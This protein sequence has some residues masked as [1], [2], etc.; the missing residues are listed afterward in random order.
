MASRLLAASGLRTYP[1]FEQFVE[2]EFGRFT[3]GRSMAAQ[4]F[5]DV[6]HL[7]SRLEPF[8]RTLSVT[9]RGYST[10]RPCCSSGSDVRLPSHENLRDYSERK[11]LKGRIIAGTGRSTPTRSG[12]GAPRGLGRCPSGGR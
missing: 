4:V 3:I 8:F 5:H 11:G 7:S 6:E 1:E 9:P 12:N 10:K 2:S